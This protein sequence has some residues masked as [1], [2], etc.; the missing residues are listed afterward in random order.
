[1]QGGSRPA[2]TGVV[3]FWCRVATQG[4]S[5]D[6]QRSM[7]ST[8]TELDLQAQEWPLLRVFKEGRAKALETAA[9]GCMTWREIRSVSGR[10]EDNWVEGSPKCC[11]YQAHCLK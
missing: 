3:T 8:L 11:V 10:S 2:G 7:A 5:L 4:Q 6:L 9:A 1:M